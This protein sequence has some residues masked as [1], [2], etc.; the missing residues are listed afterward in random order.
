MAIRSDVAYTVGVRSGRAPEHCN[1]CQ[2][3]MAG[4]RKG[5]LCVNTVRD[6]VTVETEVRHTWSSWPGVANLEMGVQVAYWGEQRT[7]IYYVQGLITEQDQGSVEKGGWVKVDAINLSQLSRQEEDTGKQSRK[8]R[9][10]GIGLHGAQ[11]GGMEVE[12]AR[13]GRRDIDGGTK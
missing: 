10:K 11:A 6:W 12:M 1:L 7:T 3:I 8:D 13:G 2:G 9:G 4:L 5:D